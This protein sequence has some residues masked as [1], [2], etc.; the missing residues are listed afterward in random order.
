MPAPLNSSHPGAFVSDTIE[1]FI[2]E[3]EARFIE[4]INSLQA[5]KNSLQLIGPLSGMP[6]TLLSAQ[7]R[8]SGLV[9]GHRQLRSSAE[10][11]S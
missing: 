4:A 6:G 9:M 11:Q 8:H 3:A 5:A 7:E 2:H 1:K 10:G